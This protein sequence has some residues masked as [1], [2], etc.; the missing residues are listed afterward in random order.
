MKFVISRASSENPPCEEAKFESITW[1]QTFLF[2]TPEEFNKRMGYMRKKEKEWENEGTN[3]RINE[4]GCIE[5]DYGTVDVWTIELDS[6]DD[7]IAFCKRHGDVI[8]QDYYMN[9]YYKHI[10]IYDDYIE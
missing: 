7:L 5:R 9:R 4:D 10:I 2:H 8:I 3:H 6:L 1:V